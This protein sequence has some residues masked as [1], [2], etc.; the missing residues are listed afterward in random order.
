MLNS[1]DACMNGK[2]NFTNHIIFKVSLCLCLNMRF[3]A[4]GINGL[5]SYMLK[6]PAEPEIA[7]DIR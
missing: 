6:R 5:K 3:V 4:A 7:M 1:S 2:Y